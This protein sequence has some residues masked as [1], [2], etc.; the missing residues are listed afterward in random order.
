VVEKPGW[1]AQAS[2]PALNTLKDKCWLV[3]FAITEGG[4][5]EK[6]KKRKREKEKKRKR[7]KEKKKR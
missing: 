2:V 4:K 6:E 3:H 1:F 5:R 7:E